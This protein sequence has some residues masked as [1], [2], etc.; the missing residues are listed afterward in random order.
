MEPVPE[1]AQISFKATNRLNVVAFT[2]GPH[3]ASGVGGTG[4]GVQYASSRAKA[5]GVEEYRSEDA[6]RY[7]N[8]IYQAHPP[9]HA[10]KNGNYYGGEK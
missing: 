3:A 2:G 7:Q 9:H 1:N 6:L 8:R 4:D 5:Y 10:K